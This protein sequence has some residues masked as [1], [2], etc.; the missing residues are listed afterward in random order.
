MLSERDQEAAE[1]AI[2]AALDRGT[3][4]ATLAMLRA[5]GNE[6][7][8]YLIATTRDRE[9]GEE[10]YQ[11]LSEELLRSLPR[12]RGE[13]SF[14]TFAYAIAWNLVREHRRK[15]ARRKDEPL[16]DE[17]ADRIPAAVRTETRSYLKTDAREK[18]A[19]LRERLSAE[20]QT[21]L[22]LRVERQMSW[23]DV[24]RVMENDESSATVA[25]LRKRHERLVRKLRQWIRE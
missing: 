3:G 2:R 10:L 16:D 5:Y 6:L 11:E 23:K 8:G 24:A 20:D 9:L 17:I 7:L 12:F 1:I 13:S 15:L 4:P 21:L 19:K 18:I 22:F 25:S 14:R